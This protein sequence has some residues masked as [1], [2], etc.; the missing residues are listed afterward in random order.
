MSYAESLNIGTQKDKTINFD[1]NDIYDEEKF[2]SFM[3]KIFKKIGIII[4]RGSNPYLF[5]EHD[6]LYNNHRKRTILV[7]AGIVL[8]GCSIDAP[9][10]NT[11]IILFYKYLLKREPQGSPLT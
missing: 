2:T 7:C 5:I 10:S 8:L 4:E 3:I 6:V 1:N 11:F 9:I